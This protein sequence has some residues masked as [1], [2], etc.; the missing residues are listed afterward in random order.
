[1]YLNKKKI[2]FFHLNINI[3]IFFYLYTRDTTTYVLDILI[4][5]KTLMINI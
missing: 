3:L 4:N 5:I 2:I 1:M